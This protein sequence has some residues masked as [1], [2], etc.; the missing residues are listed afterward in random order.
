MHFLHLIL[1]IE[2][3]VLIKLTIHRDIRNGEKHLPSDI[4]LDENYDG[5]YEL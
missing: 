5:N 2:L 4:T 3:S 1:R